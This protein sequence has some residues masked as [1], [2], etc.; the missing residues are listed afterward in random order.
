ME[1]W[2]LHLECVQIQCHAAAVRQV[3]CSKFFEPR[4]RNSCR[5]VECFFSELQGRWRERSEAGGIRSPRSAGTLLLHRNAGCGSRQSRT[6]T[7]TDEQNLHNFCAT[8]LILCMTANSAHVVQF[9]VNYCTW[10]IVEFW[11]LDMGHRNPSAGS[12]SR[13]HV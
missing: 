9:C 7:N 10:R 2:S 12:R 11:Y 6:R 8:L 13:W 4:P 1:S 3:D 5:Q